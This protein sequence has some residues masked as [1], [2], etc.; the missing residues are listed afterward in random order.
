[1]AMRVPLA[2]AVTYAG[3]HERCRCC[4]AGCSA[5]HVRA[6][7]LPAGELEYR[8]LKDEWDDVRKLADAGDTKAVK[9]VL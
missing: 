6:S 5:Q 8:G 2:K 7:L 3:L 9:S 4:S 1:M